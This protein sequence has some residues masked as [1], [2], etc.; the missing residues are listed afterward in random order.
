M[1]F[2]SGALAHVESTWMDP[3]G[4]RV[5][6]EVCGSEGMLEF[7]SR[8]AASLRTHF[9]PVTEPG[10]AFGEVENEDYV[11]CLLRF[12]SGAPAPGGFIISHD[13]R[14]DRIRGAPVRHAGYGCAGLASGFAV[15]G[16]GA[17]C[18]SSWWRVSGMPSAYHREAGQGGEGTNRAKG[19]QRRAGN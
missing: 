6:F 11:N 2:D 18:V 4:F 19:N 16:R 13:E 8:T 17:M 5:T 12:A 14:V 10:L 7:D 15:A 1:T 9:A 3:S